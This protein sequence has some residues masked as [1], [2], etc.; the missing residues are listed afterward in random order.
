MLE[1]QAKRIAQAVHDEAG[2]LLAAVMIRLEESERALPAGCSPCFEEIRH[3]LMQI[4]THLRE[5]SHDLRPSVLDD[6]GLTPAVELLAGRVS[7][8]SRLKITVDSTVADRLPA[9]IETALYRVIQESLTNV[10]RHSGAKNVHIQLRQDELI[11]CVVRDDGAGFD[12]AEVLAHRG[13]RGLG[14]AGIRE[15]VE[16]LGG[17]ARIAS[18][19]GMGTEV[20]VAIPPQRSAHTAGGL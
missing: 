18:N 16:L 14:L 19:L 20:R 12:L 11:R 9:A 15:R 2:Q 1:D 3:M 6:F 13:E 8:R 17:T 7:K 10:A 4:E 5:L